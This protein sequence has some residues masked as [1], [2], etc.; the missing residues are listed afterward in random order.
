MQKA[1]V[2]RNRNFLSPFFIVILSALKFYFW[3]KVQINIYVRPQWGY[4][5]VWSAVVEEGE[6]WKKIVAGSII[7]ALGIEN[8][9]RNITSAKK[10]RR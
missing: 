8:D 3:I 4:N 9:L 7:R 5:E 1:V 10:G 2:P 6:L